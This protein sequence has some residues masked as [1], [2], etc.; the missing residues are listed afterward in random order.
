MLCK[1]CVVG[2][3][4]VCGHMGAVIMHP[5]T[6]CLAT[7]RAGDEVC[8]NITVVEFS[9]R[10]HSSAHAG[11]SHLRM[12]ASGSAEA[13]VYV[14]CS[15]DTN[16]DFDSADKFTFHLPAYIDGSLCGF[17]CTTATKLGTSRLTHQTIV[18]MIAMYV[19]LPRASQGHCCLLIFS[20]YTCVCM[21]LCVPACLR[22]PLFQLYLKSTMFVCSNFV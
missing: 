17:N 12:H 5:A 2:S 6:V 8:L 4:K 9:K 15:N 21:V 3:Q 18:V 14:Q 7:R 10:S 19:S 22:C 13:Y 11:F 16:A 20:Y 1:P